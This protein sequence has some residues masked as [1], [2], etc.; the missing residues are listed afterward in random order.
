[1]GIFLLKKKRRA[2]PKVKRLLQNKFHFPKCLAICRGQILLDNVLSIMQG[3]NSDKILLIDALKDRNAQSN[4]KTKCT[5]IF[6]EMATLNQHPS[7]HHP[8]DGCPLLLTC[9]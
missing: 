2:F 1:M 4:P 7:A 6:V 5:K 8:L 9:G 3:E